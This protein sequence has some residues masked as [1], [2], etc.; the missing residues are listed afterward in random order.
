MLVALA[1]PAVTLVMSRSLLVEYQG[2]LAVYSML[3]DSDEVIYNY[4]PEAYGF[5]HVYV[6]E[7][8]LTGHARCSCD[9]SNRI[10]FVRKHNPSEGAWPVHY[11]VN[12]FCAAELIEL[13]RGQYQCCYHSYAL[14]RR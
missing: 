7:M 3:R 8:V 10:C 13:L 9:R 11:R 4:Q 5:K 2:R 1:C 14:M 6:F 12:D